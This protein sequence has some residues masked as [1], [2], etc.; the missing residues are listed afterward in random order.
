MFREKLDSVAYLQD[1]ISEYITK[2]FSSGNLTE[3]QSEQTAGLLFVSNNIQRIADRCR[4]ID[5]ICGKIADTGNQFSKE[6]EGELDDCISIIEH[7]LTQSIEAVKQGNQESAEQV[8]KKV[9]QRFGKRRKKY[10]KAHLSRVKSKVC[11]AAMTTYYSGI[12]DNLDRIAENC[13]SI[14][15][16]AMDNTTFVEINKAA[17]D[18]DIEINGEAVCV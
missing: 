4:D 12:L 7:L 10:S 6:A 11:N 17:K 1:K 13:A 8:F 2:L 5:D 15:E 9:K 3:R 18:A 16:E 14:A